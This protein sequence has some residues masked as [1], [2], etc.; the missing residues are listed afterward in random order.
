[1]STRLRPDRGHFD[2]GLSRLEERRANRGVLAP[3][4]RPVEGEQ[5]PQLAIDVHDVLAVDQAKRAAELLLH[6]RQRRR[7]R[8]G[9]RAVVLLG[10][11]YLPRNPMR[12]AMAREAGV[13]LLRR[14]R[15]ESVDADEV[16]QTRVH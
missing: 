2:G 13:A 1:M 11:D 14:Y 10:R 16:T 7:K 3:V 12:L 9:R 15:S 8:H 4:D 5:A 6:Q